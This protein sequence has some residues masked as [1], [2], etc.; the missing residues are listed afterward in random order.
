[1]GRAAGRSP[2]GSQGPAL[3]I[4]HLDKHGFQ[5]GKLR[6]GE[7]GSRPGLSVL[8]A[9]WGDAVSSP[10]PPLPALAQHLSGPWGLDGTL[11]GP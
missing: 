9:F 4:S 6:H 7:V 3:I 8:A 11:P 2:A 5:M 1:M 10:I